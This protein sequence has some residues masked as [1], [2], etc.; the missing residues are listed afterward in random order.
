[1]SRVVAL[2]GSAA[3]ALAVSAAVALPARASAAA[4]DALSLSAGAGERGYVGL[5]LHATPGVA[6]TIRDETTGKQ[7]IVTPTL[8]DSRLRRFARWT[9]T[10]RERRFTVTQPGPDGA[11]LTAEASVTTPSCSHRLEFVAPRSV[12]ADRPVAASVRDRWRLG[13]VVARF[14]VRAPGMDRRCRRLRVRSGRQ[15]RRV[16]FHDPRPGAYRLTLR[17]RH[18]RVR[19]T[20]RARPPSGRLQVLATGDSMIQIIDSYLSQR[21][22]SRR[23]VRVRSDAR[24]STGISKP[25]LLDWQAHARRQ[26]ASH[27]DV[28]VMFIGAN[29]G[30]SMGGIGCCGRPWIAEYAR[31]ARAMMRTYARGGRARVIWLLLPGA[32]ENPF[33]SLFRAVNAGLRRAA[34][35]L[36][37]DVRLIDLGEVFTPGGHYRERMEV[38]GKV[39][40]VRNGDGV[41]LSPAGASLV[42][43]LLI[44]TLRGER[45]LSR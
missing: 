32:R 26:A 41:H 36:E 37:D 35:G 44:R 34:R 23:D 18:Q 27:P 12:R 17:T 24:I 33:Q 42:A 10:E 21:I 31:R 40:K 22:G 28:V 4:D 1:M 3:V 14:C 43:N 7:R 13:G 8:A 16:R 19:R 6:A 20:V 39:V 30:F 2:A 29:D 15:F 9:C 11:V 45:M 5:R 38:G 25:S